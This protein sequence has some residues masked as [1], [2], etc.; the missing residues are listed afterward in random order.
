MQEV[1]DW[2]GRAVEGVDDAGRVDL[3]GRLEAVKGA[4]EATQARVSCALAESIETGRAAAGVAAGKR[5]VGVGAQVALARRES[6]WRGSRHLG[7]AKALVGEMPATLA[8]L[9][10][11]QISAWAATLVV[12]A[13]A[14]LSAQ[15]RGL[16][17][18]R[19]GPRLGEL[20]EK[21]LEALARSLAY[22]LDPAGFVD[23][24]RRAVSERRVSVRPAPDAM[25]YLSA[26]LPMGE[27]VGCF[28]ALKQAADAAL[29]AGTVVPGEGTRTRDQVMADEL[30]TRITGVNPATEGFPVEVHVVMDED[31]LFHGGPASGR[32]PHA[33]PI[34]ATLA[35][36]LA[37]TG[38]TRPAAETSGFSPGRRR[39]SGACSGILATG[40]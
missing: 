35:R 38:S 27:A 23:R 5:S 32:V 2:L 24:A 37:R 22:E 8:A 28:A 18:A 13:T 39:G 11:G 25:A 34:P 15:H 10:T 30:V 9:Q 40:R 14:C 33:G 29:A 1:V 7:M 4:A 19:I 3:I 12:R 16:V 26:L 36:L 31:T 6:P 17:D 20:S 21:H